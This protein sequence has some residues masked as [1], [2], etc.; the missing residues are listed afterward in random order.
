MI[1]LILM[2]SLLLQKQGIMK[3]VKV[4]DKAFIGKDIIHV[5]VFQ[6]NDER[7]TYNMIYTDGKS[8]DQLCKTI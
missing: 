4:A 1:A 5:A 3:V 2:T 6:K 8:G 7:T